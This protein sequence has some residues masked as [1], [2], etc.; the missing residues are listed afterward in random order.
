MSY[1]R[2]GPSYRDLPDTKRFTLLMGKQAGVH[3]AA[4]RFPEWRQLGDRQKDSD[5][6][7]RDPVSFAFLLRA[8][9]RT[10]LFF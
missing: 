10:L 9:E 5:Q 4:I 8:N 2:R 1:L 3:K 6:V 7:T